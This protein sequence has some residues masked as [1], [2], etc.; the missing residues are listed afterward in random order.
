MTLTRAADGYTI[1]ATTDGPAATATMPFAVTAAAPAQ[2]VIAASPTSGALVGLTI[3]VWDGF[4]NL[5]TTYSGS[6]TLILGAHAG[7]GRAAH[8]RTLAV[9]AGQ[10]QATFARVKLAASGRSFAFQAAADGLTSGVVLSR[11][12]TPARAR[13]LNAPH[14]V[15][16]VESNLARHHPA[17]RTITRT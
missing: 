1:V 3:S 10:G 14:R 8:H 5:E 13:L 7:P 9:T 4:G 17:D 16:H 11:E 15:V 6:V 12:A 2:L